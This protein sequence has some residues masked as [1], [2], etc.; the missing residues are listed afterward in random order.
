[1]NQ[2][3]IPESLVASVKSRF[4][5]QYWGTK[6]LYVG[7]VEKVEVG[8]EGWNLKHTDFFLQL[9][10]LSKI[11][12]GD[13][14][15]LKYAL[16]NVVGLDGM[17]RQNSIDLV[18]EVVSNYEQIDCL[19][20]LPSSFTDLARELGYAIDWNNYKVSKQIELGWVQLL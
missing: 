1:M 4:F 9:K 2:E 6:T 3:T 11:T 16:V 17:I 15:K 19:F 12:N 13:A 18:K 5:A 10:P 14:E 20:M 7:G 8:N